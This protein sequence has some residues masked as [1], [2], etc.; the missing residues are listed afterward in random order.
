M[1]AFPY[2]DEWKWPAV[3]IH[4]VDGDTLDVL[5]DRGFRE[6][7]EDRIRLYGV[8]TPER[9]EPGYKEATEA[10]RA[11]LF[12]TVGPLYDTDAPFP[13]ICR[14]ILPRDKYGRWLATVEVVG[15]VADVSAELIVLGLGVE[16]YG[17]AR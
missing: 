5:I 16:Y 9:G 13:L 15:G 8:N 3:C 6:T 10:L 7:R 2:L 4:V 11:M 1:T 17:G 12:D 14:T